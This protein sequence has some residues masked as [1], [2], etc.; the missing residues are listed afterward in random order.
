MGKMQVLGIVAVVLAVYSAH[1][2]VYFREEFVDGGK[3][4]VEISVRS[5]CCRGC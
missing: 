3:F 5:S 1:A 2:K 4:D